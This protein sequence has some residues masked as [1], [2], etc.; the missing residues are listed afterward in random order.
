MKFIHGQDR[1]QT[2]LFPVSLDSSIDQDNE[3]RL[4]DLFIDSL[5]LKPFG[6]DVNFVDNGRPIIQKIC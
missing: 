6:F 5:G 4:I 1:F 2:S 3:I